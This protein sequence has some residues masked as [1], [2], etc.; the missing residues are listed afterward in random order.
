MEIIFRSQIVADI[1]SS[2]KPPSTNTHLV[3]LDIRLFLPWENVDIPREISA[4]EFFLFNDN[5]L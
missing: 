5:H 1:A 4:A 3:N 2:A